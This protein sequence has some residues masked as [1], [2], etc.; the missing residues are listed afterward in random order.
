MSLVLFDPTIPVKGLKRNSNL[1]IS[2]PKA[3][4]AAW[5]AG[6]NISAVTTCIDL[7]TKLIKLSLLTTIGR[8]IF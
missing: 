8:N 6:F 3:T 7:L 4:S 2:K 5:A 1:L